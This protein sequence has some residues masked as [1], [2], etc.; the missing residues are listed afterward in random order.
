M[1][2]Q[3]TDSRIP[4][5]RVSRFIVDNMRH[6]TILRLLTDFIEILLNT[7]GTVP[8]GKPFISEI[9]ARVAF[10]HVKMARVPLFL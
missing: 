10:A 5:D 4:R 8:N 9:R 2:T 1:H 3:H 7:F 6:L